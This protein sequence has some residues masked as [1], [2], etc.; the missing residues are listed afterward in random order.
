[1]SWDDEIKYHEA[2]ENRRRFTDK[3]YA[4]VYDLECNFHEGPIPQP[5]FTSFR[6]EDT[7]YQRKI[8]WIALT[9]M[10]KDFVEIWH[11]AVHPRF[12]T[13]PNLP[14]PSLVL[15]ELRRA[16]EKLGENQLISKQGKENCLF[17]LSEALQELPH[18]RPP[19]RPFIEPDFN[20]Y[21]PDSGVYDLLDDNGML[22]DDS[23]NYYVDPAEHELQWRIAEPTKFAIER[24]RKDY[25]S[26]LKD[27]RK[28]RRALEAARIVVNDTDHAED[29][30]RDLRYSVDA[31]FRVYFA[32]KELLLSVLPAWS[33]FYGKTVQEYE[34]D[35]ELAL[36]IAKELNF[37]LMLHRLEPL[38]APPT[39][40]LDW[41][42]GLRYQ[43]QIRL[44]SPVAT[45]IMAKCSNNSV[46]DFLKNFYKCQDDLH[47]KAIRCQ[48]S[49]EPGLERKLQKALIF[50]KNDVLHIIYNRFYH[51]REEFIQDYVQATWTTQKALEYWEE[52]IAYAAFKGSG[53]KNP[54]TAA[55]NI[56]LP[57]TSPSEQP[58]LQAS[59]TPHPVAFNL[60]LNN[61]I[62]EH[63]GNEPSAKDL[64]VP[65]NTEPGL[66]LGDGN[67]LPVGPPSKPSNLRRNS[68]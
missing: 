17:D 41:F 18:I 48:V 3:Y 15:Y 66:P 52:K 39:K 20:P 16:F 31:V 55:Y 25:E 38:R 42:R 24:S 60:G 21:A 11:R 44:S 12:R 56:A 1:M 7:P 59:S 4:D 68:I 37:K 61:N 46:E 32:Q 30:L 49:E 63:P 40:W 45:R 29:H 9:T 65:G 14:A 35:R 8:E 57:A 34:A 50:L 47:Y 26:L 28:F 6:L 10:M 13:E 19:H 53:P 64:N 22:N 51:E 23:L 27:N 43:E 33:T 5:V 36:D 54:A 58:E 2:L 67:F 62:G